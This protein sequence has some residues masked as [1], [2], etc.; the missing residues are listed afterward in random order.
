MA[1]YTIF[2]QI[3]KGLK[4]K[5]LSDIIGKEIHLSATSENTIK[6]IDE[7]LASSLDFDIKKTNK[8][9]WSNALAEYGKIDIQYELNE[10]DDFESLSGL[11]TLRLNK[12]LDNNLSE[13]S[14]SQELIQNIYDNMREEVSSDKTYLKLSA[15]VCE[16]RLNA[17]DE[18]QIIKTIDEKHPIRV[19]ITDAC[20]TNYSGVWMWKH[21]YL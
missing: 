9:K 20:L 8:A 3:S 10:K 13:N 15:K 16:K 12:W 18:E 19:E 6:E 5:E 7:T 1:T 21:F 17:S 14:S 11:D 4:Y 2:K